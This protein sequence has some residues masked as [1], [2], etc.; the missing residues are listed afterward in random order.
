[1]VTIF[2]A[3][4]LLCERLWNFFADPV[5]SPVIQLDKEYSSVECIN[6][7]ARLDKA[8]ITLTDIPPFG[9]VGL[10]VSIIE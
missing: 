6:C 7:E 3:L 8:S 9:F 4:P 5:F 2:V 10:E 1:M